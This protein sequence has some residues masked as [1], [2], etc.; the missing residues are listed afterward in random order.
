MVMTLSNI[1]NIFAVPTEVFHNT[2]A[3]PKWFTA[4]CYITIISIILG[5]F[6]LPFT[7]RI[8]IETLSAK[9]DTEQVQ[10]AISI[11]EQFKYIGLL[12]V[13][14]MLLLKWLILAMFLYFSAIL[15]NAQEINFKT[16]YAI[17]VYSECIILLM[18]IINLLLLYVR[19]IN[20]INNMTDLQVIL[21]LDYFIADKPHNI[22]LFTLLSNFNIFSVW[23]LATLTIGVSVVTNFSKLK[24]AILVSSIWLLGIGVQVAVAM[25]STSMQG[26]SG[27]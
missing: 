23:Y 22:P 15:L 2:K 24:S 13:P 26:M 10:K 25:F 7:Q 6:L 17:I 4:F 12:F 3:S 20:S 21:G 8:A 11:S 18:G 9:L 1:V 19:G 5:Y 27:Q 14:V 16:V